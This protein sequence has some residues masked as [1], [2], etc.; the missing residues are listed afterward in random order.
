VL[1]NGTDRVI[2]A[3]NIPDCRD[4]DLRGPLGAALGM[5]VFLEYDGHTAVLGEWWQG[6]G[7]GYQNVV[8]III[9]TGIGGGLILNGRLV[10]GRDRLAG[11][12]GWFVLTTDPGEAEAARSRG[13]WE[14]LAAGPGIARRAQAA[15]G[16]RTGLT[17]EGVFAEA[18]AG[19]V[20]AQTLVAETARTIG[21]GVANIVSLVNPDIVI[22]GGGI[23][24]QG[25]LILEP[26]RQVVRDWAQPVSGRGVR[27]EVSQLGEEAGLLGAAYAAFERA[28]LEKGGQGEAS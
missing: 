19:G 8:F 17:A 7:R 14:S 20:W 2:W 26:V 4:V 16:E 13:H 9:G 23:G 27:V 24:T 3:P 22:L 12:A 6:A 1:E 15:G 11:A 28:A 10:R 21:L 5:P 25:D 18:R